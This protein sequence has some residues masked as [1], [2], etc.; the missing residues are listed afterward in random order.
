MGL[1]SGDR[2]KGDYGAYEKAL[3]GSDQRLTSLADE[4]GARILKPVTAAE[5]IDRAAEVA[6]DIGAQYVVSY[7][8]KRPLAEAKSGEYR[9]VQVASRR[10]GL[11]VRSRRGYI[12]TP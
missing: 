12:A 8:P 6:R 10:V 5:M 9:R 4:T 2:Q 7:V 11:T 3:K 1:Q